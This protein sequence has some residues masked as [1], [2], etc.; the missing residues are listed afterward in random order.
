M[1]SFPSMMMV[2]GTVEYHTQRIRELDMKIN[3]FR[4]ALLELQK[5]SPTVTPAATPTVT[6]MVRVGHLCTPS[7]KFIRIQGKDGFFVCRRTGN[8]HICLAGGCFY[9]AES[10][11]H[12]VC[13]LTG[14][15]NGTVIGP[16]SVG[17]DEREQNIGHR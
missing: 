7:C 13:S 6:P 4:S 17:E 1:A 9:S 15:S 10:T 16:D 5:P 2:I 3:V 8:V 11:S 12:L 14:L